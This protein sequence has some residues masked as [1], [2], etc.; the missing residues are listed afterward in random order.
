MASGQDLNTAAATQQQT[1]GVNLFANTK[2]TI[3]KDLSNRLSLGYGV[4]FV[5]SAA[6]SLDPLTFSSSRN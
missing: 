6:T 5:P 3:E 2:Y 1:T 4:R